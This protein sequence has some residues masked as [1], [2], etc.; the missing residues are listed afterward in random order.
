MKL[1]E[2]L[3]LGPNLLKNRFTMSPLTRC[4]AIGNIP[5]ALM[6]K[7]YGQRAEAGLIITEGTS[8]SPNGLGYARIPGVYSQEQA[9]GWKLVTDEVH[10]KGGKIFVQLMH[11]GRISHPLN[12]SEKAKIMAPSS[13]AAKGEMWTDQKG[14][15][16]LP[17]PQ[18]MTTEDIEKTIQ[19]YISASKLAVNEAGFDGVE[20]HGANGYLIEQFL[21]P[22]S[23]QRQDIYGQDRLQ[24]GLKIA[25]GVASAIG[26]ERVGIRISPYGTFN[27]IAPFEGVDQFYSDFAKKLSAIGL[28]YIHV[29]DYVKGDVKRLIRENFKG[30]YIMAQN[31]NPERAEK[32]LLEGHGDL[33][34][35]GRYFI[36][37]PNLPLKVKN[38]EPLRD[39]D[40]SK[41]YTP[42]P[43]GYTDY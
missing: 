3:K 20:L 26:A 33:V 24:F 22:G 41:F 42:G 14:N 12:M 40:P 43:E 15:Q 29:I 17:V 35:F 38:G 10:A 25:K 8:P 5:N 18:E 21:N 23:N 31:Y 32:D 4:R 30:V 16:P 6:A 39:P 27:D 2:Q 7:Y 36:S 28:G 1:F 19:E 37:N 13:I 9:A 11:T 34:A